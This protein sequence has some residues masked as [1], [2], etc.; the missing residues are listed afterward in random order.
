M[1]FLD[2]LKRKEKDE[3]EQTAEDEYMY[4]LKAQLDHFSAV[5]EKEKQHDK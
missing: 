4:Y 1:A 2:A 3:V 5:P